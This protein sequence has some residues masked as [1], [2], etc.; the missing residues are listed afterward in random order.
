MRRIDQPYVGVN[1]ADLPGLQDLIS[2][3]YLVRYAVLENGIYVLR[4][5]HGREER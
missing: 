3:D 2:G 1:V 5:W 4:I